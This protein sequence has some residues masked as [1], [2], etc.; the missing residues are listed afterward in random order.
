LLSEL[1]N[2]IEKPRPIPFLFTS[3]S[4]LRQTSKQFP[5]LKERKMKGLI[6]FAA[7]LSAIVAVGAHPAVSNPRVER[8]PDFEVDDDL[9]AFH[10]NERPLHTTVLLAMATGTGRGHELR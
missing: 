2:G 9:Y 10:P 8:D 1:N 3:N 4:A 6:L 5:S 7:L